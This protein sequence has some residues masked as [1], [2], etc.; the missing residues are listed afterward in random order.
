VG[1]R[2][3]GLIPDIHVAILAAYAAGTLEVVEWRMS[4]TQLGEF[5]ENRLRADT[6]TCGA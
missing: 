6:S 5:D 4:G 1:S 3:P 2:L